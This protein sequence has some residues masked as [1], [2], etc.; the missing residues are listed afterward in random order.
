M[1]RDIIKV[2]L[3]FRKDRDQFFM[4]YRDP[5]TENKVRKAT[6]TKQRRS[7]ERAAAVWEK[8]LDER[9]GCL[10]SGKMSWEVFRALYEDEHVSSLAEGTDGKVSSVFNVFTRLARPKTLGAVTEAM[11]GRYSQQLRSSGRSEST[12]KA[13]LTH[14]MA[15]LSWAKDRDCHGAL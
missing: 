6:G 5:E 2:S 13:H 8:E 14:I 1:S 4:Q 3:Y 12:I 15:A 9:R 10:N 7:A 11:L